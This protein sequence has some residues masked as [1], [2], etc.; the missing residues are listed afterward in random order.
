MTKLRQWLLAGTVVALLLVN[1]YQNEVIAQQRAELVKQ[2]QTVTASTM[3]EGKMVQQ[4]EEMNQK[5]ITT[6]K[7][8]KK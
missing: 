4:M 2:L 8:C 1:V 5:L 3:Q 6:A 7:D